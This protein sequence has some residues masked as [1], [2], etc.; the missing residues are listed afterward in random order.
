VSYTRTCLKSVAIY[1]SGL[2]FRATSSPLTGPCYPWFSISE[3]GVARERAGLQPTWTLLLTGKQSVY[4][5]HTSCIHLSLIAA[6]VSIATTLAIV[7]N[8]D[9]YAVMSALASVGFTN[10]PDSANGFPVQAVGKT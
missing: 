9:S 6:V 1:A 10:Y 3:G 8:H 7:D 2:E 5:T 4:R